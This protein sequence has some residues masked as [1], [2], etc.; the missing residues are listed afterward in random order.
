M[1]E[2]TAR[3]QQLPNEED[4]EENPQVAADAPP[5]Y[6]S[7]TADNAAY[8]DYKEDGAF[9]KPPSYNV[10]TTL[11]SYDEA[12]RT[13]AETTVPLVTGRQPQHR[14]RLET[15]DDVIRS[16]L[17][18]E[19][20]V[21]RDD[22]EDADQLRIGNDGIFMLTFFMAFLFNWIGF[23]LS[24]CLTTSAAGRYGA[25]SGFGLSLIKWILIVRFSTYF[26]GYFDGQYW[27][28]WV[29]LV[30]GI[31]LFLRGFINYARIRKMADT[32]STLPRTRVLFI[33]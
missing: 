22:F 18:D 21:T 19:D 25:I 10:A 12:E 2:P 11:P 28:W 16:S 24:F 33:Y 4:P 3:Y 1:A 7:I 8:F 30:F 29:F 17:E 26:P 14:E 23:F 13:K 32:F 5:P 27:L 15:F 6:S 9:P 31:L 20:F